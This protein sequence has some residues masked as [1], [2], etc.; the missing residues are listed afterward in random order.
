ML[1]FMSTLKRRTAE[2][3]VR[4]WGMG[5]EAAASMSTTGASGGAVFTSERARM[6]V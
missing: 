6:C 5:I 3:M 1:S 4:C 2:S